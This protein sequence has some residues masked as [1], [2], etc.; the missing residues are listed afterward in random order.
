[1]DSFSFNTAQG[2]T[3]IFY[4]DEPYLPVLS[5]KNAVYVADTNTAP[6]ARAARNFSTD[7]PLA[8]IEAGET[9]KNFQSLQTVLETALTAG[10]T[11]KGV[12]IGIG[13][14]MVCDITAFAA[15]IYMRGAVCKLVPTSLLAMADAAIGGKTAINFLN[16]KNMIGTFFKS[17]EIYISVAVLE[18]LNEK[19]YRSGLA[20]ILK[21]AFLY[22]SELYDIFCSRKDGIFNRDGRVLSRMIR[23]A[24]EAKARTV[25]RDF[26]EKG[27]RAFLNF[28]HTFGHALETIC[29][30]SIPHG[31]AVAWGM[32]RALH[33][34]KQ[35]GLTAPGYT[36]AACSLIRSYGYGTEA[37]PAFIKN[38][39]PYS[40]YGN[41]KDGFAK[42]IIEVMK[43][44]KK[45]TDG[46]INLI[47]QKD[48]EK[49]FIYKA[50]EEAI[51]KVL[52]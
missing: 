23:L 11:R 41:L 33:F 34:G 47:L 13:G 17:G 24:A 19:E 14:G 37:V 40:A 31:N 36:D 6:I 2:R 7:I 32:A 22:S 18:S 27:E 30:F 51:E 28:G 5:D 4:S 21:T 49:T 15:S 52:I 16:Y 9:H 35:A 39:E 1:M 3:D 8:V 43:K 20:E 38:A 12:F 29:G 48:R 45:N 44:D 25:A 50:D 42:K 10:L 46:K 26:E